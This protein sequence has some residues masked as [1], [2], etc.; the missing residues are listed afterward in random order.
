MKL[1][2]V[3]SSKCFERIYT[4][5]KGKRLKNKSHLKQLKKI[6]PT[7]IKVIS[8]LFLINT[9]QIN[10]EMRLVYISYK[11]KTIL[12]QKTLQLYWY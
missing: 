7:V 10:I 1:H 2:P 11:S 5:R 12:I 9:K 6:I 3:D 8:S 4:K